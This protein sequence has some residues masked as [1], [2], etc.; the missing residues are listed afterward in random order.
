MQVDLLDI[1]VKALIAAIGVGSSLLTYL[2]RQSFEEFKKSLDKLTETVNKSETGV[3]V[4]VSRSTDIERRLEALESRVQS[5]ESE[6]R[7]IR[8]G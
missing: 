3:A 7:Q 6:A 4:L 5:L 8:E 1:I 2:A